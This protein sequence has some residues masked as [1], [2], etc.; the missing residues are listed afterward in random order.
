MWRGIKHHAQM[1]IR[2][3]GL[4]HIVGAEFKARKRRKVD[5]ISFDKVIKIKVFKF[6]CTMEHSNISFYCYSFHISSF[7]SE[8]HEHFINIWQQ[9]VGKHTSPMCT[10]L[11]PLMCTCAR[12][13]KQ[14]PDLRNSTARDPPPPTTER[15][16]V[17]L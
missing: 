17:C 5:L 9:Y 3:Y 2:G 1:H 4:V 15:N 8:V 6:E 11:Y 7:N 13:S 16:T 10:T 14:S 12:W